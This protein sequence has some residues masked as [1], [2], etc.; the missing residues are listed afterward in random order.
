[1]L[2]GCGVQKL[3]PTRI[4]HRGADT[5]FPKRVIVLPS[6]CSDP[7][8]QGVDALVAA[9]L[10]FRGVDVVELARLP[11]FERTRTIVE[12]SRMSTFRGR[13]TEVSRRTVSV[14]GAMLSDADVWTQREALTRLGVDGVVRIRAAKLEVLP[15]RALAMVRLT[16]STDASLVASSACEAEMSRLDADAEMMERVVR[17]ALAGVA[18]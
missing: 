16:R 18:Q 3:P 12:T 2:G 10:A 7:W 4:V 9:E 5:T 17:C 8:C 6:G 11:A 14:T 13:A 1:M 15:V